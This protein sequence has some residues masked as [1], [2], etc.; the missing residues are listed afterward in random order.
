MRY[1]F[2]NDRLLHTSVHD[3][4]LVFF[5]FVNRHRIYIYV[6]HSIIVQDTVWYGTLWHGNTVLKPESVLCQNQTD[7]QVTVCYADQ[8]DT[9]NDNFIT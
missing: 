5:P 3:H 2:V 6:R 7:V 4:L 9:F 1:Y 8:T